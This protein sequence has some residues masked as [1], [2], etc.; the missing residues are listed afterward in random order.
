MNSQNC[1]PSLGPQTPTQRLASILL[2]ED[3]REFIAN[4]RSA[5]R[6]W[7]F[8]ARDLY[9]AT[10]GQVDVTYETLRQWHDE[11]EAASA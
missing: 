9:N 4:R 6:P 2:E 8:I 1:E 10:D 11:P 5:G 7:R 3:V